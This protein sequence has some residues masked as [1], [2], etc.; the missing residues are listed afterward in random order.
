MCAYLHGFPLKKHFNLIYFW[1][2]LS[3]KKGKIKAVK[4]ASLWKVKTETPITQ[5]RRQPLLFSFPYILSLTKS[6]S[7]PSPRTSC[8]SSFPSF[9]PLFI[10]LHHCPSS[11]TYLILF[12]DSL[13]PLAPLF[14]KEKELK[15]AGEM[16]NVPAINS[17]MEV[18]VFSCVWGWRDELQ[19]RWGGG[20]GG[21]L[22]SRSLWFFLTFAQTAEEEE[23]EGRGVPAQSKILVEKN[24]RVVVCMCDWRWV[25]CSKISLKSKN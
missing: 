18:S 9:L 12:A 13:Q 19:E 22:W 4:E 5:A 25:Y 17:G 2:Q 20:G 1:Y 8:P 23:E 15:L 11:S 10:L 16:N 3:V 14:L 21:G 24:M 7:T 6:A